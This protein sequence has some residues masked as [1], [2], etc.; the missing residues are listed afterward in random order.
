MKALIYDELQINLN[1]P[2][3]Q[4]CMGF[5]MGK[6]KSAKIIKISRILNKI[7]GPGGIR[8]L[9]QTWDQLRFLHAY[10]AIGFRE[11]FGHKQPDDSLVS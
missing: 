1:N 11:A 5:C 3:N 6:K 4:T 8:T 7:C 9:V 2:M 10:F